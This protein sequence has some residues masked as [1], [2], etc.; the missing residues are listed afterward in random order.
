MFNKDEII[1][2]T[3]NGIQYDVDSS[4]KA[5]EYYKI[6]YKDKEKIQKYDFNNLENKGSKYFRKIAKCNT[7]E[8]IPYKLG[9]DCDFN[10]NEKKMKKFNNIL[11]QYE[12]D[13]REEVEKILNECSN[14]HHTLKNFSLMQV[15]GNM[16]GRKNGGCG[17]NFD[18]L[19]SFIYLLSIYYNGEN[20]EIL[21]CSTAVNKDCLKDFLNEYENVYE[22]CETFYCLEKEFVD[23]L[24]RN[25]SKKIKTL[26][27]ILTYTNLAKEYWAIQ[28]KVLEKC[29][30]KC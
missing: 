21:N 11:A 6:K 28:E 12:N 3:Q 26:K 16:Q 20:E 1:E 4:P 2:S 17:D 22:Y 24:I 10:F 7:D 18:R 29:C 13:E 25:G 14:Q 19:D 9:G 23:K 8:N 5:W 30:S 27:D 15:V